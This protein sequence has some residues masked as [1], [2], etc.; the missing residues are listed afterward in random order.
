MPIALRGSTI[1]S[2]ARR[3]ADRRG[4][5]RFDQLLKCCTENVRQEA[6]RVES[7]PINRLDSSDRADSYMVIVVMS[8]NSYTAPRGSPTAAP[9]R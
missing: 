5:L 2:F 6:V 3:G 8:T 7:V 9:P 4:Q 1:G